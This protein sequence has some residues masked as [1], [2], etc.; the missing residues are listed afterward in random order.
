MARLQQQTATADVL[1]VMKTVLDALIESAVRLGL[2]LHVLNASSQ[3]DFEGVVP[4][5]FNDPGHWRER[6][7]KIMKN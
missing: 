5:S 1:K 6:F 2:E 3:R 4:H 7:P